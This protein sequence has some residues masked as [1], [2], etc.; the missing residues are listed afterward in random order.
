MNA[1]FKGPKGGGTEANCVWYLV[2]TTWHC[3]GYNCWGYNWNRKRLKSV[4]KLQTSVFWFWQ[5][6][7]DFSIY[8]SWIRAMDK[9]RPYSRLYCD[10][11]LLSVQSRAFP[12]SSL[13]LCSSCDGLMGSSQSLDLNVKPSEVCSLRDFQRRYLFKLISVQMISSLAH[14][15]LFLIWHRSNSVEFFILIFTTLPWG[16]C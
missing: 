14:L 12:R 13:C 9:S 15:F 2:L 11:V 7:G 10:C 4:K 1:L 8:I 6:W 3:C 16:N 5:F